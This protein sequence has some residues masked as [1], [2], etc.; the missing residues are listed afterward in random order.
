MSAHKGTTPPQ[1]HKNEYVRTHTPYSAKLQ[2]WR[3]PTDFTPR[4][5]SRRPQLKVKGSVGGKVVHALVDS[6][7]EDN[8]INKNILPELQIQKSTPLSQPIIAADGHIIVPSDKA[9]I[10]EVEYKFNDL[11]KGQFSFVPAP[12]KH[13]D[14][15]LGYPWLQRL[16]PNIDWITGKIEC[17]NLIP[18]KRPIKTPIIKT[19]PRT[20][21]SPLRTVGQRW[22]ARPLNNSKAIAMTKHVRELICKNTSVQQNNG[23]NTE[24]RVPIIDWQKL[25][26]TLKL[27]TILKEH[28]PD[29]YQTLPNHYK[30]FKNVFS[31]PKAEELAKERSNVNCEI[32]L[33]PDAKMR[34]GRVYKMSDTELS[35]LK[36]YIDDGIQQ[37]WI[38]KSKSPCAC[39]VMFRTKPHDSALRLCVDYRAINTN[40]VKNAYPL[41]QL[42]D[43]LSKMHDAKFFTKL[44][45]CNAFHLLRMKKGD[46]WKT[47]FIS[48]F[49][50]YKYQVMPF[51]LCNAPATFQ[52]WMDNIFRE[53]RETMMCYL[54]D[55][56]IWGETKEQVIERTHKV[57]YILEKN[58]LYAKLEKCEFEVTRTWF[59]GY[60]IKY[61]SITICPSRIS[62]I[63]EW[64][65]PKTLKQVQSFLGFINFYRRFIPRFSELAHGLT[66]LTRKENLQRRFELS[67]EGLQS[68]R[69]LQDAFK[70]S[71]VLGIW[72]TSLPAI[73]ETDASCYA[74]AGILSQIVNGVKVPIGFYSKKHSPEETR[75]ATPDQELMGI[76]YSLQHWRHYLEGARHQIT[77][78]S[79]H[80]NLT[81]FNTT[82]NLN[83]RQAGYW[84]QMSRFD[85]VIKHIAGKNNPA[86]LPS[87]R[88][89]YKLTKDDAPEVH[90][91]LCL[92][93]M[94]QVPPDIYNALVTATAT[95]NYA[96]E[97]NPLDE[98]SKLKWQND[99][100]IYADKRAYVP[101]SLQN[102]ILELCHDSPL[103]GHQG[104]ARTLEKCYRNWYWPY[105]KDDIKRYVRGCRNCNK[106]KDPH[107]A[108]YGKLSPLPVPEGRWTR[109]HM[110]FITDFPT[111]SSGN[112]A[113]LIVIDALTKMAHFSPVKLKGSDTANAHLPP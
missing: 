85:Y 39:P 51:G 53:L 78:Y 71:K 36:T 113:I 69:T 104:Q 31:K 92:A 17:N 76:C 73:L 2:T 50:L 63:T 67:E 103:A 42:D 47:A 83:R 40:T 62:L 89:D 68:F 41:P 9:R 75:Y 109:V 74:I 81:T 46:E 7:A 77:V 43:Y 28:E 84:A 11:A 38:R 95:D 105:M 3:P 19:R 14:V 90:P 37:G 102:C 6:G 100:L 97:V 26:H 65:E 58:G 5:K 91:F 56:L 8:F 23:P 98:E 27:N 106:N 18:Q 16:N 88:E 108:T 48:Q 30:N 55:I 87:R 111:T 59:L 33:K 60:I 13:Q 54:D 32:I 15:I 96:A 101:P 45:L 86:D 70:D 112:N 72:D 107:H 82:A 61:N 66:A 52:A 24:E 64:P 49:G 79:D 110:D 93:T 35:L 1:H 99:I 25:Y 21:P 10:V 12:L 44:D 57:L 80:C 20:F 29:T 94:M 34:R 22:G 4:I